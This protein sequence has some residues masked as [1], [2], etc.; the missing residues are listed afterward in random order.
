MFGILW[1][2]SHHAK[3]LMICFRNI[4]HR[5]SSKFLKVHDIN[6][7]ISWKFWWS[8]PLTD[9][10]PFKLEFLLLFFLLV[11]FIATKI[12]MLN[13][14]YTFACVEQNLLD[15]LVGEI[16]P[17]WWMQRILLLRRRIICSKMWNCSPYFRE[18]TIEANH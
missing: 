14:V 16:S 9:F 4:Q 13:R 6:L 10:H 1:T 18:K 2:C 11:I 15:K 5:E 12:L 8:L 7:Y 17:P 3:L